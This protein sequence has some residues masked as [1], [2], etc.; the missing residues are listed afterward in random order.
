MDEVTSIADLLKKVREHTDYDVLLMDISRGNGV[1]T[2]LIKQLK[3]LS[4][5]PILIF[6]VQLQEEDAFRMLKAGV[7][8]YLTGES[9]PDELIVAIRKAANG[10]KHISGAIADQIA[11]CIDASKG[12]I[13]EEPPKM[14]NLLI[15]LSRFVPIIP[16]VLSLK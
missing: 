2:D 4:N 12:G 10:K 9:T 14:T 7:S 13:A 3:F 1:G 11:Y 8:G 6:N 15:R 5:Q 16:S